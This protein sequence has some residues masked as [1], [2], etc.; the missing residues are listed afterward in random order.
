MA[1]TNSEKRQLWVKPMYSGDVP[2]SLT[3]S[4]LC[5]TNARRREKWTEG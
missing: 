4:A 2:F 5:Q 1:M 3:N